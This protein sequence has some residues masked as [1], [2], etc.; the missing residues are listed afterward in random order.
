MDEGMK[1]VLVTGATGSMGSAL[2]KL[3][4]RVLPGP[5]GLQP[6]D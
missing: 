4:E 5:I 3:P 6:V 2:V 1:P